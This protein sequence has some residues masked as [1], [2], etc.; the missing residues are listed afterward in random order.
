MK[1]LLLTFL[2]FLFFS[3]SSSAQ[4][5]WD[6]IYGPPQSHAFLSRMILLS[7]GDYLLV[8]RQASPIYTTYAVRTDA[9]GDTIWT[10]KYTPLGLAFYLVNDA[11][12]DSDGNLILVGGGHT[13]NPNNYDGFILKLDAK[14]DTIWMKKTVT[15]Q[16]DSY[17]EIIIGA[18]NT[19]L[20]SAMVGGSNFL[21]KLHKDGTVIWSKSY[22]FS[23]GNIGGVNG[24]IK[25][26]NGYLIFIGS[27]YSIGRVRAVRIDE[28]GFELF[29]YINKAWQIFDVAADQKNNF[30]VC[31]AGRL[32]KFNSQGDTLWSISPRVGNKMIS[33]FSAKPTA[34]GNYIALFDRNN[35][36]DQDIG[37]MKVAPNGTVIKDT[38]LYR[39]RFTEYSSDI[40]VDANGDYVFAGWAQVTN[41]QNRFFLAK[42]RK[43]NQVID[44]EEKKD[45][46]ELVSGTNL[47]PNPATTHATISNEDSLSGTFKLYDLQGKKIWQETVSNS[48]EKVIPLQ[49]FS[50][51]VYILKFY[52]EKGS[53]FTRKVVKQ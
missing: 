27:H 3:I 38:V 2:A 18:N 8:G 19:C 25:V 13:G 23:P 43:W 1:K 53:N 21:Q 45:E 12:E 10:R 17:S 49:S 14:G 24:L 20:V 39:F 48:T 16:Y 22:A 37:L 9:N 52:S 40:V 15:P 41:G 46:K 42:H 34:D 5:L 30:L 7:N 29:S 47:Y 26:A 33:I 32:F 36:N 50:R 31:G 28:N 6:K 44:I 11:V 4:M 35:G 51:G